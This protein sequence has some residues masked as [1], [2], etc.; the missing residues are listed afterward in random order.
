MA[1]V[2]ADSRRP[3]DLVRRKLNPVPIP[4]TKFRSTWWKAEPVASATLPDAV[5]VHRDDQLG[6]RNRKL[7]FRGLLVRW[8]LRRRRR[9]PSLSRRDVLIEARGEGLRVLSELFGMKLARPADAPPVLP[10]LPLRL[11]GLRPPDLLG[12]PSARVGV[13]GPEGLGSLEQALIPAFLP[14]RLIQ[15][16]HH[17]THAVTI[18]VQLSLHDG[19]PRVATYPHSAS[20]RVTSQQKRPP[21][22]G[23]TTYVQSLYH[24]S[25]RAP[26]HN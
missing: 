11:L 7:L 21:S 18:R 26:S 4:L 3:P 24:T 8:H 2:L 6:A 14:A 22:H 23:T 13:D 1:G 12:F 25:K 15:Q 16:R 20:M 17:A 5:R 10:E 19:A 9:G